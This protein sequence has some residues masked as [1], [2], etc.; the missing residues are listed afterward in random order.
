MNFSE[1]SAES[2][3]VSSSVVALMFHGSRPRRSRAED[4]LPKVAVAM[5]TVRRLVGVRRSKRENLLMLKCFFSSEYRS[6][7]CTETAVALVL[8]CWR[9]RAWCGGSAAAM[10]LHCC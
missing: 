3:K 10:V 8:N 4:A 2:P 5:A 6:A 9:S 1:R 7:S